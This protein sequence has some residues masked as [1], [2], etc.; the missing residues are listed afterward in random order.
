MPRYPEITVRLPYG[1][2]AYRLLGIVSK[3]L[4]RNDVDQDEIDEFFE[5][6]MSSDYDHLVQTCESWVSCK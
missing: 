5:E 2:N 6:A 1:D 4:R 3:A